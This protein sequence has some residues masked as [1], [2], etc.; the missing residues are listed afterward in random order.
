MFCIRLVMVGPNYHSQPKLRLELSWRYLTILTS[1]G[2]P[3]L[4]I[5]SPIRGVQCHPDVGDAEEK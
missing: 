4:Q 5:S 1:L 3:S 2:I